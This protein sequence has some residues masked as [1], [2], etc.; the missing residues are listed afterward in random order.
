MSDLHDR[1]LTA[2]YPLFVHRGVRGVSLYEVQDAAGVSASEFDLEFPSRDALAEEC[3]RLREREWTIGKI[4][5]G[6]RAR[7]VTPEGR[8]LAIF[9]VFD[10]WFHRDDYEA[11]TFVNVLLEM[12][13][14][15]PLGRASVEYLVHIRQLLTALASEAELRDSE[16]FALSVH[17]LMKGSIV[18]A[19]MGD[20]GAALRG[21]EMARDLIARHR[22]A[23]LRAPSHTDVDW[24]DACQ[25]DSG[26]LPAPREEKP[27]A[28]ERSVFFAESVQ[29]TATVEAEPEAVVTPPVVWSA[30]RHDLWVGNHDG[31]FAGMV[32]LIHGAYWATSRHGR[33]SGSYPTLREAEEALEWEQI[34]AGHEDTTIFGV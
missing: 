22:T 6:A 18:S 23:P 31:E 29:P 17:L 9:D 20:L 8:L 7:G 15:H 14:E 33:P 5:E 13:R 11:C 1:I 32:E 27:P 30:V 12:G 21:K 34:H 25:P 28:Q 26:Y 2:A 3:L 19:A 24:F 10:E 16:E 4:A